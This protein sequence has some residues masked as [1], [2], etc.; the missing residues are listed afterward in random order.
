MSA[1]S[2]RGLTYPLKIVNGNLS[3][4]TDLSLKAQEIR[5]IVETRF[6]ER[7]M[8]ADYGVSDRTL[9]ILEPEVINSELETSI[10]EYV[11][12]LTSVSVQGDWITSGDDG[13]YRIYILYSVD[14]I[15]QPPLD[16]SL[17]A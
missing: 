11:D 13:L 12:G 8:R 10:Q 2:I 9:D 15:P 7:V 4:S 17:S 16:F 3:T 6:F 5:S 14:G 1:P